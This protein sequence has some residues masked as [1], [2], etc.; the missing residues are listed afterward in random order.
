MTALQR[1]EQC[2]SP[3]SCNLPP[4]TMRAWP[5]LQGVLK[6]KLLVVSLQKEG[7]LLAQLSKDAIMSSGAFSSN[8]D[9]FN[10]HL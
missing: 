10:R 4:V 8:L 7:Q 1:H 3:F 9:L 5:Q 2:V 6:E